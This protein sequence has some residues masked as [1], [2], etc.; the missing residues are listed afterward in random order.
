MGKKG[1]AKRHAPMRE[2]EQYAGELY[3]EREWKSANQAAHQLKEKIMAHGRS[4]SAP[5]SEQNAQRTI[6]DWFRKCRSSR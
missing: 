1:A 3:R 2:L 4:I 5:L 6:A